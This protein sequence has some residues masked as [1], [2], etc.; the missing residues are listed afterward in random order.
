MNI[1]KTIPNRLLI[2]V[3]AI[4]TILA[5]TPT[6]AWMQIVKATDGNLV[7]A[8]TNIPEV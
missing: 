1:K 6:I 3:L 4:A 2:I 5:F 7:I 8:G